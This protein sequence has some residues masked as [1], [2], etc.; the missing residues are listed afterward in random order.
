[1]TCPGLQVL[2]VAGINDDLLPINPVVLIHELE[3]VNNLTF[4]ELSV[5]RDQSIS[6]LRIICLTM[7]SKCLSLIFTPWRR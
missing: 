3:L 2:A 4:K 5:T 6:T 7:I 1:M